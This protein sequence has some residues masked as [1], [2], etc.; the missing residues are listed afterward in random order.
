MA[1]SKEIFEGEEVQ[2]V[3]AF[4]VKWEELHISIADSGRQGYYCLGCKREMQ[5]VKSKKRNR[6]SYFRHDAEAMRGQQK[7][8]YSDETFRHKVAK[9]I[10]QKIQAI[11]VPRVY[12][13]HP[14]D[15]SQPAFF[16]NESTFVQA[17]SVG[18]EKQF[19]EDE[20]G[21]IKWT[22]SSDEIDEKFLLNRP[23]VTFFNQNGNPILFI[24]IVATHKVDDKKKIKLKRLG[25]DSIQVN[26]PRHF[27]P[28]EIEQAFLTT[29]Y[30][31]WIYNDKEQRTNYVPISEG[32]P[33][34]VS[35]IDEL[36]GKLFRESFICRQAQIRALIRSIGKC[37]GSKQYG[38]ID[39]ALGSELYRVEG[40]TDRAREQLSNLQKS[41]KLEIEGGYR[42]RREK[43]EREQEEFIT[44]QG[45]F[46]RTS[47][48]LERR[49]FAKRKL[50]E[51]EIRSTAQ[52]L[53]G[54]GQPIE[55]RRR[56]LERQTA[57][58]DRDI[59]KGERRI[60]Q[61][62][63]VRKEIA[64]RLQ[65]NFESSERFEKNEIDRIQSLIIELPGKYFELEKGI[66]A[67]FEKLEET[68]RREIE[69]FE[70]IEIGFSDTVEQERRN[71]E[72]KYKDIREGIIGS[73]KG[74]DTSGSNE[75]SRR[76]NEVIENGA[77]LS[78]LK[79]AWLNTRRFRKAW[80]AF[81]DGS[82]E[83]WN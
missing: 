10:L 11:K 19:Y 39:A 68:E 60:E 62:L 17:H 5:A 75:F 81:K 24:E 46:E 8:Q 14:S 63:G 28:V 77:L 12:K 20:N 65:A 64:D 82:Y 50:L 76:I 52:S 51:V 3:W 38:D 58:V 72:G 37:L 56:D 74:R 33:E 27:S 48:D 34:G 30:T 80:N 43:F 54:D 7:C 73:I 66:R 40:N 61:I 18:I 79:T 36:Q 69:N 16:I 53:G 83:S 29:E 78:D 41:I 55:T 70:K 35:L 59:R 26:I 32:N 42:N 6:M 13:Y 9:E 1:K 31:K 21:E 44:E 2:N 49:Y 4:N 25:I 71:L 67:E 15:L 22:G 23:D 47:K 57:E 45:D